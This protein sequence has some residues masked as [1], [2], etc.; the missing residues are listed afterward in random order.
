MNL[1]SWGARV[2]NWKK[3]GQ[4]RPIEY[5]LCH[6]HEEASE[7]FKAWRILTAE[8]ET[9]PDMQGQGVN[10]FRHTWYHKGKPEGFAIELADVVL[11]A[12]FIAD[13]TGIDLEAAMEEKMA[14]NETRRAK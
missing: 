13:V 11:V 4:D 6:L 5:H 3:R 10:P 7:V 1:R 12:L 2:S 8:P 14:Y 9:L